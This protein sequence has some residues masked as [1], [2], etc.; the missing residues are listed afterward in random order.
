MDKETIY[1]TD[2]TL[3]TREFRP[4]VNFAKV[5]Q[6]GRMYSPLP[7]DYTKEVDPAKHS[8]KFSFDL[9]Q[10]LKDRL[11]RGEI[12]LMMPKDGL[13]VYAGKDV[14]E[15]IAKMSKKERAQLIHRSRSWHADEK[16]VV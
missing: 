11:K 1:L 15:L 4:T 16:D 8:F 9:P 5:A 14:Q 6:K 7:K 13:L 10:D 3:H 2:I 12:D